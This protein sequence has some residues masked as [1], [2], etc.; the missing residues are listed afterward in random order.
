M[1]ITSYLASVYGQLRSGSTAAVESNSGTSATDTT[2]TNAADAFL[3]EAK[4]TPAQRIREDWLARHKMSEDSL[5]TMTPEQ[6]AA[7]EKDI[8]EELKRKLTGKDEQRGAV[9]NLSA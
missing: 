8:A 6:R 2:K 5:N 1:Q 3:A 4:K 9:L 7:A